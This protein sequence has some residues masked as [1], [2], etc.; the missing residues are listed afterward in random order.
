MKYGRNSNAYYEMLNTSY[1][2]GPTAEMMNFVNKGYTAWMKRKTYDKRDAETFRMFLE[3]V[4]EMKAHFEEM[5][6]RA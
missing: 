2:N 4:D 1:G 6:E 3:A 5:E